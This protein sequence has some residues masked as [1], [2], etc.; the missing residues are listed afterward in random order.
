MAAGTIQPILDNFFYRFL[1]NLANFGPIFIFCLI[2]LKFGPLL[3][4]TTLFQIFDFFFSIL[5]DFWPIFIFCT[6]DLKFGTLL[7]S[8][9]L[10]QI[11]VFFSPSW[12]IFGQLT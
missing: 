4:S 8:T 3:F 2:D 9:T 10:F 6:I 7:F 1:A 5:A 11:F 12:L